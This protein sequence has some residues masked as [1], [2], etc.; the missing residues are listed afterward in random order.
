[1]TVIG[2]SEL[3]GG[4][5]FGVGRRRVF[6][7]SAGGHAFV[8]GKG[9]VLAFGFG[10]GKFPVDVLNRFVDSW[11]RLGLWCARVGDVGFGMEFAD[12][13]FGNVG[14]SRVVCAQGFTGE[15]FELFE[16]GEFVEIAEAKTHEEFFGR[17]VEDGA[18]DN[19]LA[20]GSG[21]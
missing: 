10:G 9:L 19:F 14:G 6:V 1:M 4:G 17:L 7:E 13:I 18:A 12:L 3:V 20:S 2:W 11:G 5:G 16:A 21:D 15:G 8:G